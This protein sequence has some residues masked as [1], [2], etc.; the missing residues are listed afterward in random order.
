MR[1]FTKVQN[2]AIQSMVHGLMPVSELFLIGPRK[3]SRENQGTCLENLQQ[4]KIAEN[5]LLYF[6]KYQ[7]EADWKS[8]KIFPP[9]TV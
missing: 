8:K 9:Q 4:F 2:Y 1:L 3:I 5:F 6:I 7:S